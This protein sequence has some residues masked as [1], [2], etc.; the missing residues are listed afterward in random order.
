MQGVAVRL[1][2]MPR[3]GEFGGWDSDSLGGWAGGWGNEDGKREHESLD[4]DP[5]NTYYS[6][7]AQ[8]GVPMKI[9]TLAEK[10]RYSPFLFRWIYTVLIGV[11]IGITAQFIQAT[12]ESLTQLRNMGLQYV[13]DTEVLGGHVGSFLFVV[14]YNL[15]LVVTAGTMVAFI[16]PTAAGDGIAQVKG[17][18]NGTS[19]PGVFSIQAILVTVFG[20]ILASSSALA[21]G[22]EGPLIHIGANIAYAITSIDKLT[23]LFPALPQSVLARFHNDRD[24]RDFVCAG[25]GAG[26]AAA[27]GA[28]IGGVLF[29]L[30]E[31]ASHWTPMLIIRIFT[32]ALVATFTLSFIK[33]GWSGTG[34]ISLSGLLSFGNSLSIT[35][36]QKQFQS[37]SMGEEAEAATFDSALD[38]PV[39]WWELC[40]FFLLGC[41]GGAVGGLFNKFHSALATRRP[42]MPI[43]K[44]WE[45]ACLSLLTSCLLFTLVRAAPTCRNDGSWT[46]SD[47]ENWGEWCGGTID[48]STCINR[49]AGTPA[50]C[51]NATGWVC[52][53]GH[54][55]GSPCQ[56][57]GDCEWAH[58]TCER[59]S[60]HQRRG[61]GIQL[62][63]AEGQYDE[64]AT[65]FFG[66]QREAIVRMGTRS[67]PHE[68]F[69]NTS[70]AIAALAILLLMTLTYG[71]SL[72]GGFF[73]PSWFIGA[74]FGRLFGQ[75]IKAYVGPSVYS[76]AYS[77]AGSAAVL[78]GVQ[79]AS[80]FMIF[81]I[82][83]AT[84]NV[85]FLLPVAT[86]FLGANFV[87]RMF[88]IEG[89]Y[90][91]GLRTKLL[92]YLPHSAD[93]LMDLCT[94]NEVMSRPVH[95]MRCIETIGNIVDTLRATSHNGFPVVSLGVAQAPSHEDVQPRETFTGGRFEGVI[96][97]SHL[98][99]LLAARFLR[100][101][102]E[103]ADDSLWFR[104]TSLT[105]KGVKVDGEKDM[106]ELML[107]RRSA[108]EAG[109]E[110]EFE[111]GMFS[112]EDRARFVNLGAYMNAACFTVHEGCQM[113]R[114]YTLFRDMGLRH[115]PVVN[116]RQTPIGMLTRANFSRFQLHRSVKAFYDEEYVCAP[117]AK[118]SAKK[119]PRLR[120]S[121]TLAKQRTRMGLAS[122]SD[123]RAIGGAVET[124]QARLAA[125][126][127]RIGTSS[128]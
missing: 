103:T 90:D 83:E 41:V 20:S 80:I 46:C 106:F 74:C 3:P 72:P 120:M 127:G 79:R 108:A 26:I 44:V 84:S 63:C 38:A 92:R 57:L 31:A 48:N 25:A 98:R 107:D 114:A 112:V 94:V 4:F 66:S 123:G 23:A 110:K 22:P 52:M 45:V 87:S 69:T 13:W 125:D 5:V 1:G 17:F 9:A 62:G 105:V 97:R 75:V 30:E 67:H 104:A 16:R 49:H 68:P 96:L 33:A 53:G 116:S 19:I 65:L 99:Q 51:V 118:K 64:L 28:P 76:G 2:V 70:L 122:G 36:A 109:K 124:W 47:A 93:W 117:D 59:I 86:T 54:K 61:F 95:T 73:M 35:D 29:A 126:L 8:R 43:F 101:G 77:L 113:S 37:D 14:F 88:S 32:S 81:I 82:L 10:M 78:C 21:C 18:L 6:V 40:L 56:G 128:K 39:L 34:D 12:I 115:L 15:V 102:G 11:A 27:F 119:M 71:T 91:I 42:K 100:D 50:T 111:W 55:A 85:H 7:D 89:I 121:E 24:R 60:S 58:G